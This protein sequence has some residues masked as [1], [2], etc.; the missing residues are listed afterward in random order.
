MTVF[1]SPSFVI[2]TLKKMEEE[3]KRKRRDSYYRGTRG[4]RLREELE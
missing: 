1:L 2:G 4:K 3:R